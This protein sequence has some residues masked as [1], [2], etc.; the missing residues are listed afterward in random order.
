[1]AKM[2]RDNSV[3]GS[4][5]MKKTVEEAQKLI[6]TVASNQHLYSYSETSMKGEV[7]TVSTESNLPKQSESLTQ[8]LHSL[9]QQLLSLKKVL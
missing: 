9:T 3:G 6:E 5:H 4:I 1:M 8:Q 2:S 7:K